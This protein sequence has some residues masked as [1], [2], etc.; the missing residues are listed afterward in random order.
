MKT[1]LVVFFS[2]VAF[3]GTA[4]NFIQTNEPAI[5]QS[6]KLYVC[7]STFSNLESSKGDG[8][9]WDFSTIQSD[10][11]KTSKTLLVETSSDV[12][13]SGAAYKTLI[14]GFLTTFWN[15]DSY[16]RSSYGFVFNDNSIGDIEIRFNTNAEK[17]MEYPFSLNDISTDAYSGTLYN[18]TIATTGTPCNGS[19][20]SSVDGRGTLILPGDISF[21]NVLR[22]KITEKTTANIN[23][24]GFP[25]LATVERKQYDYY[26]LSTSSLPLFSY[27]R[28]SYA[29]GML[30]S[31]VVTLVLSSVEPGSLPSTASLSNIYNNEFNLY[32]N[33]TSNSFRINGDI[34]IGTTLQIIDPN[35]REVLGYQ[36]ID[37]TSDIDISSL[38]PGIYFV[39]I[40]TGDKLTT[41]RIVVQ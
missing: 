9:I 31:G 39:N 23:F 2:F 24:L 19:I 26:D 6:I 5:N 7:D 18:A 38:N 13:F 27:I 28:I 21:S 22:H 8:A 10:I 16:S 14:P 25:V 11:E 36:S 29:A 34:E 20:T 40:K 17:L 1:N 37:N 32:P 30:A 3:L 15:S 35:G 4:Q 41:V 12:N 33:P